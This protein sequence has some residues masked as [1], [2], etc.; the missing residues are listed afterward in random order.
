VTDAKVPS[1]L[2][3]L[4]SAVASNALALAVAFG[5]NLSSAQTN[6]VVTLVGSLSAL[7]VVVVAALHAHALSK[8][9]EL[10]VRAPSPTPPGS[11]PPLDAGGGT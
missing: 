3:T 5:V 11:V 9:V 8:R 4:L 10:T 2:A 7:M 1:V 6:T